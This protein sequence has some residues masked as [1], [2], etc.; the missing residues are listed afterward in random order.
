MSSKRRLRRR[1]CGQK[2][3]FPDRE[4]A[5]RMVRRVVAKE[6]EVGHQ[7]CM[8]RSYRCTVCGQWHIGHTRR[9]TLDQKYQ[10]R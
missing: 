2:R 5:E 4:S 10:N 9:F 8:L 3:A 7:P 1:L 6:Y